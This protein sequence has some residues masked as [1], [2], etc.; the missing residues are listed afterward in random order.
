MIAARPYRGTSHIRKQA[1]DSES[2]EGRGRF[3]PEG[4]VR[5][6]QGYLAHKRHT[7]PQDHHRT[8]GKVSTVGSLE[9]G[10]SY[11]RGTPVGAGRRG[12]GWQV[13]Q[14]LGC[15]PERAERGHRGREFIHYKT[16]M[17]TD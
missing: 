3:S 8:L 1:E 14:R 13:A 17:I 5:H 12:R 11:E 16:S 15:G 6:L 10:V 9:G 2:R 4:H 7:P